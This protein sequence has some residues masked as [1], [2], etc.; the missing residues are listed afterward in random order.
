MTGVVLCGQRLARL[1][2]RPG[3]LIAL[4]LIFS[5]G[6]APESARDDYSDDP[7]IHRLRS[8]FE[9][10]KAP[11]KEY[12]VE[13]LLAADHHDL[14]WRL[15]PSIAMVETGAGKYAHNNNIL[16]WGNGRIDFPSEEAGIHRVAERLANSKLYRDKDLSGILRTYN[17]GQQYPRA[18]RTFMNSLGP[19]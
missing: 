4:V 8:L 2:M 9:K 3:L 14:D 19:E 18:I 13:F 11:A 17:S 12:A 16:G 15:L 10:T 7:R 1:L 6:I 5:D